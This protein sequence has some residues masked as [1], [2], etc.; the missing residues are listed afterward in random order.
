MVTLTF[1]FW[2][3]VVLFA[4]I[5]MLRGWAKEL[6]NT[7]TLVWGTTLIVVL[8]RFVPIIFPNNLNSPWFFYSRALILLV[9]LFFSYHTP[10]FRQLETRTRRESF[11]D[12]LLG[13]VLG[14]FNGYLLLSTLLYYLINTQYPF[15]WLLTPDQA[16]GLVH[17]NP[18]VQEHLGKMVNQLPE[19][20]QRL[21]SWSLAKRLGWPWIIVASLVAG[22]FLVVVFI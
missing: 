5:G 7:I 15:P 21:A 2:L 4:F 16:R 22:I 6:I 19:G 11:R 10:R 12:M 20:V 1:L 13:L 17:P 3:L 9:L 18:V 8:E 14:G